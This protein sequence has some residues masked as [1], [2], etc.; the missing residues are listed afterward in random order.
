MASLSGFALSA[1]ALPGEAESKAAEFVEGISNDTS[2]STAN[3]IAN[4]KRCCGN[5]AEAVIAVL[6]S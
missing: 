5:N 1:R 6:R 3:G 4:G 2:G